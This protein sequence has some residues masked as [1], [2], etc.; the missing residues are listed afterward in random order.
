MSGVRD[1]RNA[2]AAA[3]CLV[4]G[5]ALVGCLRQVDTAGPPSPTAPTEGVPSFSRAPSAAVTTTAGAPE[6]TASVTQRI[7]R[8]PDP[9]TLLS[10]DE[11]RTLTGRGVGQIDHDSATETSGGI[12]YCQWQ[13]PNGNLGIAIRADTV[14]SFEFEKQ[15]GAAV[16]GLGDDAYW[17]DGLLHVRVGPL[18]FSVQPR[19]GTGEQNLAEAQRVA[20][21]LLPRVRALTA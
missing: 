9:C 21:V 16:P 7:I 6:A 8:I 15:Y 17:V 1:I 5:L 10:T 20:R 13:Q 3:L 11:V 19:G 12:R 4:L 18:R 14:A 2:A